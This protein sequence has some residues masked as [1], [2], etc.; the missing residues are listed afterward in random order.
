MNKNNVSK[1]IMLCL[2]SGIT[3]GTGAVSAKVYTWVDANGQTHFGEDAPENIKTT[4]VETTFDEI[5]SQG[6]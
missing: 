3:F 1:M 4:D 5:M 2:L 6:Q